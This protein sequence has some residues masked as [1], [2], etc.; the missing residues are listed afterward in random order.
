[1]ALLGI[2][3]A[4]TLGCAQAKEYRDGQL[5]VENGMMQPMLTVSAPF[6][7][8]Y[9][10]EWSDVLRFIVYVETDHDTDLDGMADLVKVF[11]Q[12]PRAAAEG[13]FK[14]AVL[15][16]PTPYSAGTVDQ[17]E[18]D[19]EGLYVEEPFDY[20]QLYQACKK[21]EPKGS[22]TTLEH[23]K[24]AKSN[25][26]FYQVPASDEKYAYMSASSYNYYLARGF[27][28]AICSG[29]GT[30][31]SEG[32][33]LCGL[34]LERDS[35]KNVI[36]WLTGDRR[37]FTD[38]TS[39]TEIKADWCN[40][41]VAMTGA[42]YGGTIPFEVAVTG[43]K[44]LKTIL[45]V[46]G[47]ANWYD[48]TNSQGISITNEVHYAD[49][50]AGYNCGAAFLDENWQKINPK[51]GSWLWQIAQDQ[52]ETN[53]D[54]A[55]IWER[56]D[57]VRDT[58]RISC[59]ALIQQGVNDTNVTTR[60]AEQML[61]SFL[62]AGK[63]AHL[64]LHQDGH[65][66]LSGKMVDG[67]LWEET[68]NLWLSH[69]LYDVDNGIDE[70]I[71]TILAQSNVDGKFYHYDDWAEMTQVKA[72]PP[73]NEDKTTI[74]THGLPEYVGEVQENIGGNLEIEQRE[75]F[76]TQMTAPIAA[77]YKLDIP[78]NAT[79][80][81]VPEVHLTLTPADDDRDGLMITAIL[82]ETA[83]A[84]FQTYMTKT[85]LMGLLPT[86]EAGAYEPG[87][88]LDTTPIMEM[89]TSSTTARCV[90]FGW[91]DLQNPGKGSVSS[92]YVREYGLRAD[93]P[94]RYTFLYAADGPHDPG[95]ASPLPVPADLGP[96]PRVPGRKL[97]HGRLA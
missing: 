41:N 64:V 2:C 3:L 91:T 90:S 24:N 81:G 17:Y 22:V 30:Y 31:G 96:I 77:V 79:I 32:F 60:H 71:P 80:C 25:G 52:N 15:Y 74:S 19:V 86:R 83:D 11:M 26:W 61:T 82:I 53:G 67:R 46:A 72:E 42:S 18:T 66:D 23:A 93:E 20:D 44:G 10:N 59:T 62:K 65:T 27:A 69:Y 29:I 76:Y 73:E 14:A 8:D 97:H 4:L 95:R 6:D 43:V 49:A 16:D 7:E 94:L 92:E 50:L 56:T 36:E 51:Y 63:S 89:V 58:S 40:G 54:Y 70:M 37:A 85:E 84:P 1:M 34:D 28:I 9:T 75:A 45:P 13:K 12:I 57:Y 48:Y 21:R 38:R 35:H 47:I 68:V 33:E 87:G 39:E 78:E 55:P 88:D 5:H